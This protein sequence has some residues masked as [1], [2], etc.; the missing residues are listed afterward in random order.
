MGTF[1]L[2]GEGEASSWL[3]GRKLLEYSP[4]FLQD[5][6]EKVKSINQSIN[7]ARKRQIGHLQAFLN[8]L[9]Y[10]L[11]QSADPG[12]YTDLLFLSIFSR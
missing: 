12:L 8:L 1:L 9:S 3:S 11:T 7:K 4:F 10:P 6:R 5:V 2:T